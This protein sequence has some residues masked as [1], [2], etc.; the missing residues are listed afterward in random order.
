MPD[1]LG[2]DMKHPPFIPTPVDIEYAVH[3]FSE[4]TFPTSFLQLYNIFDNLPLSFN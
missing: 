3:N 4:K 2:S 1:F